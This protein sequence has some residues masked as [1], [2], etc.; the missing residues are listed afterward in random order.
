MRWMKSHILTSHLIV[1]YPV[2]ENNSSW[3]QCL[4]FEES[5]VTLKGVSRI[6]DLLKKK[7]GSRLFKQYN[8]KNCIYKKEKERKNP[9]RNSTS[10]FKGS[11]LRMMD[12]K[13]NG[14]YKV[15]L[16]LLF[17]VVSLRE[18]G[19]MYALSRFL[20]IFVA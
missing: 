13:H 18:R 20:V 19:R 3:N 8:N 12:D 15:T 11:T 9:E 16:L 10:P 2:I 4:Y 17:C 7:N 5:I 14:K 6:R 1:L